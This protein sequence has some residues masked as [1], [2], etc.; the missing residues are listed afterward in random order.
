M[1]AAMMT[2]AN[3]GSRVTGWG[4]AVFTLGSVCW[5]IVGIHS[6]Q[7]NLI[8]TNSFLTIVNLFGGWRWLGRQRAYE[9]GGRSAKKASRRSAAPALFT[10]TGVTEMI[11]EDNLGNRIGKAV[12][13]LIECASGRI[14]YVVVASGGLG[15]VAEELRAVPGYQVNFGRDR[16]AIRLTGREFLRLGQLENGDWPAKAAPLQGAQVRSSPRRL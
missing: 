16:M 3:L 9:D 11:V 6:G 5:S 8:A 2:A 7:I 14:S 4:F 13:V 10:A 1:I 15:G 12:E